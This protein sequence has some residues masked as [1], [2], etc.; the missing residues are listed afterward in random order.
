MAQQSVDSKTEPGP[1]SSKTGLPGDKLLTATVKKTALR[2]LPND[3]RV[4]VS[5]SI[6]GSSI[7]KEK[8]RCTDSNRVSGTKR[9]SS[10]FPMNHNHPQSPGNNAGNGHLVYVR[11]KAEA[12]LG[13]ST[14]C[15]NP[16]SSA[17]SPISGSRQPGEDETAQ[18][19]SQ[20]K[21]PK[22]SCFPA[23]APFPMTSSV[24]S[25]GKP[26]VPFSIGNS[27]MRLAPVESSFA[28]A[29]PAIGNTTR[30]KNAHWEDQYHQ[31]Q[32]FLR[33]LD[34][35]DQEEYIQMLQSL[36][37]IELSRHAVELEKRSIQLSLEEAK[38][39]QRVAVL[40]ILGKSLKNLKAPADNHNSSEKK[41][42]T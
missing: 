29:G 39:L 13:K 40:N 30:P 22:V 7:L 16:S 18:P 25:S 2:E 9:P 26:S 24:S 38:E 5:A 19:K 4:T 15:G 23:F 12:D 17:Y 8:G 6:G 27:A 35:S 42:S 41:A 28:T 33:K 14:A 36:S 11:R 37:S 3:N 32:M 20:I 1:G 34:Q 31:L 21:E 10:E